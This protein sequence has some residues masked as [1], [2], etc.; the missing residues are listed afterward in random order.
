MIDGIFVHSHDDKDNCNCSKIKPGMLYKAKEKWNI[1]S[2]KLF[3]VGDCWRDVACGK[4]VGC[5]TFLIKTEYNQNSEIN[6]DYIVEDL[7]SAV[8]IIKE[9]INKEENNKK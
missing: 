6:C 3:L 7:F 4:E 8:E 9:L 5:I 1:N 2:K